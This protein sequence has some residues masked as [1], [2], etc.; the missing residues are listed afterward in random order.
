MRGF[1]C[2]EDTLT[3]SAAEDIWVHEGP[4]E[5]V[6]FAGDVNRGIEVSKQVVIRAHQ[7]HLRG[8]TTR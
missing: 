8:K 3:Y 2:V 5:A 1:G 4:L 6:R 7:L